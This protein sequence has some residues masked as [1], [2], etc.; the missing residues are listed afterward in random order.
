VPYPEDVDALDPD[1][2]S[3]PE[4]LRLLAGLNHGIVTVISPDGV[5]RDRLVVVP[6]LFGDSRR[7]AEDED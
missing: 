3:V 1:W 5:S 2:D 6:G 4:E 7:L